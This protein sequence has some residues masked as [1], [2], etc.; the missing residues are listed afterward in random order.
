[1]R[2]N[3]S[4]SLRGMADP[5]QPPQPLYEQVKSFVLEKIET[6]EW[7]THYQIPSEHT[8]VRDMG[9]SRMTI[10]RALRE[11]THDGHL[12][13]IQGVGTF[14][15]KANN[16]K[17]TLEFKNIDAAITD[18]GN[19]HSS[20]VHF[21]QSEPVSSEYAIRLGLKSGETVFRAYIVHREN[22][23]PVMLEDRYVNPS[24]CPDFLKQDYSEKTTDSYFSETFSRLSHDHQ[25]QAVISSP[26]AHHFLDIDQPVPCTQINR[27]TW[28]G[29]KILS[30]AHQLYVG[31]RYQITC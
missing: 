6:S 13:R 1:M 10:H 15:S 23:I 9:I 25:L 24:L 31:H 3:K 12:R 29:N 26:E 19:H 30:V 21:L 7:P 11:L 14:V 18:S 2:K 27:R 8:L 5:I 28:T 4:I 22:G 20:T 17:E 16:M